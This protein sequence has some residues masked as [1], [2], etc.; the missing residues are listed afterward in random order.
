MPIQ[1]PKSWAI[2]DNRYSWSTEHP[3][4]WLNVPI[5]QKNIVKYSQYHADEQVTSA[6]KTEHGLPMASYDGVVEM[7]GRS[8]EELMTVSA[9]IALSLSSVWHHHDHER[10]RRYTDACGKLRFSKT[11]RI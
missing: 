1:R 11:K 5:V 7:W 3:K 10:G 4:I 9:R 2:T 8:V 6:L